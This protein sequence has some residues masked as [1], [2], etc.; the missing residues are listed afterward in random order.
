MSFERKTQIISS[1]SH[2]YAKELFASDLML[3]NRKYIDNYAVFDAL[4]GL[5]MEMLEAFAHV[6]VENQF[7][8]EHFDDKN[9]VVDQLHVFVSDWSCKFRPILFIVR[10]EFIDQGSRCLDPRV[11]DHDLT[12]CD[13][14]MK[15]IKEYFMRVYDNTPLKEIV[16]QSSTQK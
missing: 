8:A 6:Q 15:V 9:E 12:L 10:E 14:L 2:G 11:N 1:L 5:L 16:I 3:G 4:H 7:T 13:F